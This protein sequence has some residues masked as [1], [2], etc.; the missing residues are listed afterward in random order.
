MAARNASF[1]RSCQPGPSFWK[2]SSTS[3]SSLIETISLLF[4]MAGRST[5]G[6][7][8]FFAGLK[9]ASAASMAFKGLRGDFVMDSNLKNLTGAWRACSLSRGLSSNGIARHCRQ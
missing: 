8:G 7:A 1:I 6:A 2:N 4:G 5:A 9:S 3:L